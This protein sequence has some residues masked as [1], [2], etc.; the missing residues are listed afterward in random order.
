MRRHGLPDPP[1]LAFLQNEV[2]RLE[3]LAHRRGRAL[4]V[5]GAMLALGVVVGFGEVHVRQQLVSCRARLVESRQALSA[6]ARAP[7]DATVAPAASP[8]TREPRS[9]PFTIAM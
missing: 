6:L 2:A 5:A 4:L 9:G 3:A 8:A 1:E 7:R